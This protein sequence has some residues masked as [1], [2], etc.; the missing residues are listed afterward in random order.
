[1][2]GARPLPEYEL[3]RLLGRGGFGE[4]WLARGPGGFDVALKLVRLG[5]QAAGPEVRALGLMKAVRH[6]HLLALF[7]AWER[8]G[9]LLI[10]MELADRSLQDRW[11]EARGQ[12]LPGIQ[13]AELL[14]YM[15][16]AAQGIDFLHDGG[17]PGPDGGSAG[18]QHRDIKPHNLLLVGGGVKV[19]DFGLAKVLEKSAASTTSGSLTPVYASPEQFGGRASRHS[20]Q[21]SLAVSYCQLRGGRVPFVG[22]LPEVMAGHLARPPDLTMLPD[23]ER[24]AVARA[25]AKEPEERW[26]SCREFVEALAAALAGPGS[27]QRGAGSGSATP[28]LPP[29]ERPARRP[30]P[31]WRWRRAAAA[32]AVALLAL[33][34]GGLWLRD[35]LLV[36]RLSGAG[37]R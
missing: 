1:M 5:D 9:L 34:A 10:A 6:P 7:G 28:L 32:G 33:A 13:P 21:Y 18:I 35:W 27:P 24:P 25:L 4:V 16:E 8:D 20:D 2:P 11:Q 22:S 36:F 26:P 30:P 17:R 23:A 14:Q 29:E 37:G 15:R 31:R 12:G 3:V 19:A